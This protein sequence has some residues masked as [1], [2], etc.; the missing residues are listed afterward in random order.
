MKCR[1]NTRRHNHGYR[2]SADF[3]R[4]VVHGQVASVPSGGA[5]DWVGLAEDSFKAAD[6]M[7][8]HEKEEA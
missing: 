6:A 2:R 7:I 1:W 4:G 3:V 5:Y 8:A